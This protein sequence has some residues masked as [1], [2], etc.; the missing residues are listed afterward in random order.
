MSDVSDAPKTRVIGRPFE[1]GNPGGGRPAL[2][3]WFK[4]GAP[5][6]LK[7]LL[8]V[9]TGEHP[10]DDEAIRLRACETVCDR[11]YG[12]A[13]QAVEATVTSEVTPAM[14]ALLDLARARSEEKRAATPK[15]VG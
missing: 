8:A 3:D 10:V 9:A 7:H 1:K 12:K 2:P 6:A 4:S 13:P 14:Q 15:D 5:D 11:V